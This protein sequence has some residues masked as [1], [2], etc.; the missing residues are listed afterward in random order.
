MG[1]FDGI[2]KGGI[3]GIGDAVKNVVSSFKLDPTV[4]AQ[5]NEKLQETV[6]SHQE[7]L[8]KLAEQQYE[9]QLKDNQSARDREVQIATSDKAPL[10]NKIATP[11]IG[12]FVTLG[13][14]GL[15][16]YMLKYDVPAGN[17]DI[18]NVMLGSLGTAWITIVSY[19]FGSSAGSKAK[20]DTISKLSS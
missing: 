12:G 17:R 4:E 5:L 7:E 10:I 3:A 16:A 13:F 1:I 20:D 14:F 6:M 15:L 19:Y 9:A 18:L 11:V 2:F 8:Q